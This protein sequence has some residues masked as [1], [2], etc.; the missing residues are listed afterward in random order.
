MHS[1]TWSNI[2]GLTLLVPHNLM[3]TDTLAH[4]EISLAP[5]S[6]LISH[7]WV[8]L[9]YACTI[10]PCAVRMFFLQ[11]PVIHY[12]YILFNWGVSGLVFLTNPIMYKI[13]SKT[14]KP[15]SR[16]KPPNCNLNS[17]FMFK[18]PRFLLVSISEQKD[19]MQQLRQQIEKH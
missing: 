14:K 8:C 19:K 15:V 17:F 3:Q 4:S 7:C 11:Y 9:D 2:H 12:Y 18:Y 6:C 10:A 1:Q 16:Q 13:L 5:H